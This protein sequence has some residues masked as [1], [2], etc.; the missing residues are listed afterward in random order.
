MARAHTI[1]AAAA[2]KARWEAH[3]ADPG[4]WFW[5]RVK[6]GNS[7]DCWPWQGRVMANRRGYGRL[8]FNGK[9]IGAHRMAL[10]LVAPAS[11]PDLFACHTC[12]NPVCCN[13]G[14]LFW[15]THQDNMNDCVAKGRKRGAAPKI[16]VAR[17]VALRENGWP[18]MGIAAL[19]NVN[20]ASIGKALKKA[21]RA[22]ATLDPTG[23][24][25]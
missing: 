6:L 4:K 25:A 10:S 21:L 17:A 13:P 22:R 12:D 2:S 23:E 8:V 3:H 18:Y 14:H 11:S 1:T 9:S 15:G 7:C 19:M 5:K 24:K 16:D 20:Q